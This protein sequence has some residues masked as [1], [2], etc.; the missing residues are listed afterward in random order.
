ML[1][2]SNAMNESNVT[3]DSLSYKELQGLAMS[4]NL[5]GKMK[6]SF[7]CMRFITTLRDRYLIIARGVGGG[8]Q[9]P[10]EPQRRGRDDDL[11]S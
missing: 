9:G 6:V 11:G 1:M 2:T 7:V 8:D 5:P 3:V 4:L 10:T